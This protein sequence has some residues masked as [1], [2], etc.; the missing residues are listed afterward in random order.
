MK[1]P[2]FRK[3]HE[4]L[5]VRGYHCYSS[6]AGAYRY[7]RIIRQPA[8]SNL[9]VI[10]LGRQSCQHFAGLS[11]VV[12]IR[13]QD[14]PRFLKI[15]FRSLQHIPIAGGDSGM[16]FLEHDRTQPNR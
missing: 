14:P 7:Q 8:L 4:I 15:T 1:W 2:K 3:S 5:S 13:H 9:F 16:Q 12:E 11:P 10:V 6:A